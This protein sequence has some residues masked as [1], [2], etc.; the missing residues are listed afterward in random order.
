MA[1]FEM[2]EMMTDEEYME[3][4]GFFKA[5][6]DTLTEEEVEAIVEERYGL[7]LE[8]YLGYFDDED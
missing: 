3:F 6:G 7:T 4:V 1:V 8:E 5:W 2:V